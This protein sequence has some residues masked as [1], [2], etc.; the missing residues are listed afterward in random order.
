MKPHEHHQWE[1]RKYKNEN[2]CYWLEYATFFG[3]GSP[4]LVVQN[5]VDTEEQEVL[6]I[7]EP[8]QQA[9]KEDF[10]NIADFWQLS[11]K[12]GY[13]FE[14]LEYFI[15]EAFENNETLRQELI[16]KKLPEAWVKVRSK[17]RSEQARENGLKQIT[18]YTFHAWC[19]EA[20]V[21]SS[22]S[23]ILQFFH[24]TGVLYYHSRYFS[25]KIILDQAWAI[26]AIY[27]LLDRQ[28]YY[29]KILQQRKGTLAYKE[30]SNIWRENTDDERKLFI[31]FMLSAELCFETTEN[32]EW[33]TPL[34]NL[35]FVVP[36]L[37]REDKPGY[38]KQY[39]DTHCMELVHEMSYL[40][41][42]SVFIHGFIVK[43]KDFAQVE[44]MW[45]SGVY[46]HYQGQYEML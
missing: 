10:F 34:Q 19:K 35:T 16:E 23:T 25:G 31:D 29:Y 36:Q 28:G 30:I 33:S 6:G 39:E 15:G 46:L 7:P 45:Q 26:E 11:A 21:E 38:I 18:V 1:G 5:K 8:K 13:N 41:L 9:L 2:L 40:F 22:A 27:K 24:D 17:V 37:L 42:P 20:G 4:I 12:T 43:A 14:Q 44:D 3:N 32:K